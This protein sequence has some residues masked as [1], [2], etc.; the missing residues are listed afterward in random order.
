M[1]FRALLAIATVVALQPT[2]AAARGP[3]GLTATAL[4]TYQH[5]NAQLG[6]SSEITAFDSRRRELWV[7][8][9]TG[10]EILSLDGVPLQR[11][12]F[13]GV[14]LPNS[15]AIHGDT[16]AIALS[17]ATPGQLNGSVRFYDAAT[18]AFRTS[19]QVGA[20]PDM[21]IFTPNGRRLLVANEAERVGSGAA[22]I[23]P[24]GSISIIDMRGRSPR[25]EATVGFPDSVEGTDALR[26]AGV[27]IAPGKL[28]S[29]DIEPEYIA[30]DASGR[31]AYITLQENNALAILDI[32]R[33]RFTRIVG[34]GTKDFD[35]GGNE[36][37]PSDQDGRI[38]LR[39]VA[40]RGLYQPDAIGVYRYRGHD[41]LVTAN[42][43]DARSDDSDVKRAGS[44]FTGLLPVDVQRLNISTLDSSAEDLVAFGGRSFSIR[45][46]SGA[47]VYDSGNLLDRIAIE[48]G[49]HDDRRSDDR[50]VEPEGVALAKIGG[51]TYAFIGLERATTSA[52]AMFDVT[53]PYRVHFVD[54]LV[55]P[56]DISPEGLLAFR[57]DRR[58][59]LVVS[60]EVSHT[61]T[62]FEL[63]RS[64]P[65]SGIEDKDDEQ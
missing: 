58:R 44:A 3:S 53:V 48:R 47:L 31:T 40:A 28:A 39:Q 1:V 14:G 29:I 16:V 43:G 7:M 63:A 46:A 41:Y 20:T 2:L 27:R 54:L 57:S 65:S 49:L 42:E 13:T 55:K 18:K 64:R 24:P 5:N 26:S 30:L 17:S 25:V 6:Q 4:W 36:I 23:D 21:L 51:R 59:Y 34:L 60:N 8:G 32:E 19:V 61:T 45:D 10:V 11:I 62:L 22:Q 50:G 52:V 38:E 37:D 9:G 33:A 35:V 12:D 56:G 15:V